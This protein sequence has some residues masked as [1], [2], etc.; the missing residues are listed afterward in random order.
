MSSLLF[1]SSALS[2]SGKKGIIS[3]NLC[4]TPL[5]QHKNN[6]FNRLF[7][8]EL[9]I[10]AKILLMKKI[11]LIIVFVFSTT[12]IWCQKNAV[13]FHTV[14]FAWGEFRFGYERAI[15]EK[16]SLQFNYGTF[17]SDKLP[18]YLYDISLVED[19]NKTIPIKNKLS[20]FSTSIDLRLYTK[21]EAL[22]KF[23][24][25]P[26][27]KYNKYNVTVSASFEYSANPSEYIELTP[28]Q[29]D[30]GNFELDGNY[31]YDA[32]GTLDG[33]ITQIGA[34]ASI[35][36]QFIIA[37]VLTLD[38]NFFGLGLEYNSV[39]ADLITNIDVDYQK[40]LP[41]VEQ[42]VRDIPYIGDKIKLEAE[43]DKIKLKAPVVLPTFRGGI[44]LG[45]AF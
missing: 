4:L 12:S 29:Q 25:A 26:Y 43:K 9:S 3:V 21:G 2:V 32:T 5:K 1:P 40:W 14:P 19:Y 11:L 22:H 41:Y 7:Y 27:V 17:Y 34:G 15:S 16:L 18:S 31:H 13:K 23:Y 6:E 37:K 38:L 45:F 30:V 44:S 20:G 36:V 28:N 33:S 39:K 24:F 42:D 35:G 8:L 10:L